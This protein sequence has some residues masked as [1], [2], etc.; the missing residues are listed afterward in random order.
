MSSEDSL[1]GKRDP[2]MSV[3]LS[4]SERDAEQLMALFKQGKLAE[5]GVTAITIPDATELEEFQK[6]G[7]LTENKERHKR[8]DPGR[9][10]GVR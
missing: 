9:T 7:T 8:R 6:Q 2:G 1:S 5:L 4:M 10:P 3:I